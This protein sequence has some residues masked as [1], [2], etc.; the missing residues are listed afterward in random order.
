M[1]ERNPRTNGTWRSLTMGPGFDVLIEGDGAAL[2]SCVLLQLTCWWQTHIRVLIYK[3][4]ADLCSLLVLMQ[5]HCTLR[6]LGVWTSFSSTHALSHKGTDTSAASFMHSLLYI[7]RLFKKKNN[8]WDLQGDG[9]GFSSLWAFLLLQFPSCVS[10]WLL[11]S[12]PAQSTACSWELSS[13]LPGRALRTGTGCFDHSLPF[14]SSGYESWHCDLSVGQIPRDLQGEGEGT[15]IKIKFWDLSCC[16]H[17]IPLG[18]LKCKSGL[19]RGK[20]SWLP[21]TSSSLQLICEQV[22]LLRVNKVST[23]NSVQTDLHPKPGRVQI[24]IQS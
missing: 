21:L 17:I 1:V 12:S 4:R 18:S 6:D 16:F 13:G 8:K 20:L 5:F 23:C 10:W 9:V 22:K 3:Q 11:T 24:K 19:K 7:H 15:G 2:H 14:S